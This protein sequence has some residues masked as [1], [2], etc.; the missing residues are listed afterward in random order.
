MTWCGYS[1]DPVCINDQI[2]GLCKINR[3]PQPQ[4]LQTPVS[5]KPVQ[6]IAL[7]RL[8][9]ISRRAG[10]MLELQRILAHQLQHKSERRQDENKEY[11]QHTAT[12]EL[13][14]I[15]SQPQREPI[16]TA[17]PTWLHH[18]ANRHETEQREQDTPNIRR[19]MLSPAQKRT[20]NRQP[21]RGQQRG[22]APFFWVFFEV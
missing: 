3:A 8:M 13:A 16:P 4:P 22:L 10:W 5:K 15:K 14:G 7:S 2:F 9:P 20:Q 11:Q 1:S 6:R 12:D 21:Q 18:R 19:Q 17:K